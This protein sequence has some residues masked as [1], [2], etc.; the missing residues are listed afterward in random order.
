MSSKIA[1]E[2]S[3]LESGLGEKLGMFYQSMFTLFFGFTFS[4]VWGWLM[5][6]IMFG[7]FPI[8]ML[9]GAS[10]AAALK[11][12]IIAE[13]KAYTQSAGYAE[14]ALSAVRVVHTYGQESLE[15]RNYSKYLSRASEKQKETAFKAALGGAVG[16]ALFFALE[17][18]TY[19]VG[20]ILRY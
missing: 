13:M 17:G 10:T 3:C 16:H 8:M 2:M 9:I 5:T 19:G 4:F 11:G 18:Y 15:L 12:G 7:F 6:L 20:G 14:Q 1:K